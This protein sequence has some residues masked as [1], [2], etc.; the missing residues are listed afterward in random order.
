VTAQVPSGKR[1]LVVGAENSL[2]E[3]NAPPIG[4]APLPVA[5]PRRIFVN[6]LFIQPRDSAPL[7]LAPRFRWFESDAA[8]FAEYYPDDLAIVNAD[9]SGSAK[10]PFRP[11]YLEFFD[12]LL[13]HREE[14]FAMPLARMFR[15]VDAGADLT[16]YALR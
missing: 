11:G 6:G 10:S 3:S 13:I 12:Y 2:W 5:V 8:W 7:F 9:P 1:L 15:K 4:Y 14:A 16:L